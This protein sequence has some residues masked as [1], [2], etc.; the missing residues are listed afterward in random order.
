MTSRS[1]IQEGLVVKSTGS[2]ILVGTGSGEK[3]PCRIKGHFRI[4]GIRT[5]NPVA[6][7]DRVEFSAD[8]ENKEGLIRKIFPRDN[9]IIRKA[10]KLSREAHIIAANMD[11]AYLVV[12]LVSPRTSTG[13]IDRFLVTATGYY[14]PAG[15][16]FNKLDLYRKQHLETLRE[17]FR[18]YEDAGYP[19]LAVSALRGDGV[20]NL[21]SLL[22]GR[23]NLFA[24]LSGSGKSALIKAIDPHLDPRIGVISETHQKGMHTTTFAELYQLQNGGCIIDT[25]GIKEF[26]LVH[27]EAAEIPRCFPEMDRLLPQCQYNDCTHTH[28]PRCAVKEALENGKISRIRYNSY[29]SILNED[30]KKES[31]T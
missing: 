11:H 20:D 10:T 27:F 2:W 13:F 25:P 9:Y 8:P 15:L 31:R 26:G 22:Q 17:L 30:A 18:I 14:I 21:R 24:G 1:R 3:I 29:L 12:T 6:V 28:E 19:C 5:T 4:K 16:I 23:I 7:G